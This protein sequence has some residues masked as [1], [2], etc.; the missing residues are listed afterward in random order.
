MTYLN[1]VKTRYITYLRPWGL[2]SYCR[3]L[4]HGHLKTKF[5]MN[6]YSGEQQVKMLEGA[7]P[8]WLE[9]R[10]FDLWHYYLVALYWA[11]Q[12]VGTLGLGDINCTYYTDALW[13]FI[14]LFIAV[15]CRCGIMCR[16][17]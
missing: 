4:A 13:T 8:I 9:M 7:A 16:F 15:L 2:D 11:S 10:H 17:Y 5:L 3:T 14:A 1:C 6:I 12:L